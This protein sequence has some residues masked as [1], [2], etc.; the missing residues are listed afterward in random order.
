MGLNLKIGNVYYLALNWLWMTIFCLDSQRLIFSRKGVWIPKHILGY[1]L[2]Y[3]QGRS[4]EGL[5]T[6]PPKSFEPQ[7]R[8][9][10]L[11]GCPD[12]PG[13]THGYTSKPSLGWLDSVTNSC[14]KNIL[15]FNCYKKLMGWITNDVQFLKGVA[16]KGFNGA[17][18]SFQNWKLYGTIFE[19]F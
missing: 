6:P 1:T 17:Q 7:R 5:D 19:F 9:K 4:H 8:H 10:N 18:T 15:H 11:G 2:E 16:R 12:P 14:Y 13:Y 3:T